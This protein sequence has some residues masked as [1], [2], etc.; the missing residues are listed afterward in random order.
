V[1]LVDVWSGFRVELEGGKD[2]D[3][4]LGNKRLRLLDGQLSLALLQGRTRVRIEERRS[5]FGRWYVGFD[6]GCLNSPTVFRSP[7]GGERRRGIIGGT[8]ARRLVVRTGGACVQVRPNGTR[9]AEQDELWAFICGLHIEG[10]VGDDLQGVGIQ[11]EDR[12]ARMVEGC[13]P[14][15]GRVQLRR[16]GVAFKREPYRGLFRGFGVRQ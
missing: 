11:H 15:M 5:P 2:D 9:L 1:G 10:A 4:G 6:T 8:C 12:P 3:L 7:R 16:Q 13:I 14:W